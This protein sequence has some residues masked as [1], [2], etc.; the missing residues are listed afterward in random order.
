MINSAG[1]AGLCK[2]SSERTSEMN[3]SVW[4]IRDNN[5]GLF[6]D[7]RGGEPHR[8]FWTEKGKVYR[9]RGWA[10]RALEVRLRNRECFEIVEFIVIPLRKES[11]DE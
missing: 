3:E 2:E 5:T 11:S 8:N 1:F 9:H 7:P 10:L 6:F 4:K